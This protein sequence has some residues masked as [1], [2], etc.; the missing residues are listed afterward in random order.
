M[1]RGLHG[2]F[3]STDAAASRAFLRDKL[4]LP[5]TDVGD[6]WLIFDIPEADLG[7]HPTDP[8][9]PGGGHHLSF[10][11]DDIASTVA[12][13]RGRGVALPGEP[14]DQGWGW[15]IQLSIPGGIEV[16]LYQPKYAKK[17]S[18]VRKAAARV[19][20]VATRARKAAAKVTTKAKARAKKARKR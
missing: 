2:M 13:L 16:Q 3:Y 6:G 12:E 20:K 9:Q 18:P 14:V 17:R 7:F 4:Q 1:I 11:C 15:V 19:R 5:F 8:G 10:Y